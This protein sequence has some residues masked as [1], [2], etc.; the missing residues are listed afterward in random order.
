MGA[1]ERGTNVERSVAGARWGVE[2]ILSGIRE[3]EVVEK[4]NC[5]MSWE[6]IKR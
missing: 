5:I 3:C 2:V 1:E 6:V 4:W